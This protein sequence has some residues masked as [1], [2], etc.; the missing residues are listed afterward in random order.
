MLRNFIVD[1]LDILFKDCVEEYRKNNDDHF[2]FSDIIFYDSLNIFKEKFINTNFTQK[3]LDKVLTEIFYNDKVDFLTLLL[4]ENLLEL[5]KLSSFFENKYEILKDQCLYYLITKSNLPYH[6][7]NDYFL[8]E[9]IY[10]ESF[11]SLKLLIQI[12]NKNFHRL[13]KDTIEAILDFNGEISIF[14]YFINN[15]MFSEKEFSALLKPSYS[16]FKSNKNHKYLYFEIITT[17]LEQQLYYL[18]DKNVLSNCLDYNNYESAKLL[19][20]LNIPVSNNYND[21][22]IASIYNEDIHTFYKIINHTN[23]NDN[24]ICKEHF[25]LLFESK[26]FYLK[27]FKYLIDKYLLNIC[28]DYEEQ[29]EDYDIN[30][31]KKLHEIILISIEYNQYDFFVYLYNLKATQLFYKY[32]PKYKEET[33]KQ[34]LL[35]Y[36]ISNYLFVENKEPVYLQYNKEFIVECFTKP[37]SKIINLILDIQEVNITE[38]SILNAI[39]NVKS[40]SDIKF[41]TLFLNHEKINKFENLNFALLKASAICSQSF[42]L[43][44]NSNMVYIDNENYKDILNNLINLSDYEGFVSVINSEFMKSISLNEFAYLSVKN[45]KPRIFEFIMN[46]ERFTSLND[47]NYSPCNAILNKTISSFNWSSK[48]NSKILEL[49]MENKKLNINPKTVSL[50]NYIISADNFDTFKTFLNRI[51]KEHFKLWKEEL[52]SAFIH[53]LKQKNNEFSEFLFY[54]SFI[55]LSLIEKNVL[56][57]INLK[58]HNKN[59][60][61]DLLKNINNVP[62]DSLFHLFKNVYMTDFDI[63]NSL[64]IKNKLREYIIKKDN[65]LYHSFNK[66]FISKNMSK[67]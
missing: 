62:T 47:L 15:F 21:F 20:D 30:F 45:S 26:T 44:W 64:F 54:N 42:S 43:L 13:S 63:A 32:E 60:I 18:I 36:S 10:S 53:S 9:A 12:Y 17:V 7:F 57:S 19:V 40:N 56:N 52:N 11:N 67:F 31:Y 3:D 22:L 37:Y 58:E 2:P 29:I 8:L 1:N 65:K 49:I 27:D 16:F 14:S 59:F 34:S 24:F 4:N 46:D 28:I 50:L 51:D 55:D 6:F 39:S 48:N 41:L 61:I 38:K 25:E 23:F 66:T 33:L 35:S 5:D